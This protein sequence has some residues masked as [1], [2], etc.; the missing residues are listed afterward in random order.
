MFD[1]VEGDHNLVIARLFAYSV[2]ASFLFVAPV[3]AKVVL[4]AGH[5]FCARINLS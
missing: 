1:H 3:E 2:V 4:G 5:A